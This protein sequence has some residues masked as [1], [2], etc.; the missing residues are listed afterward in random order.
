[1]SADLSQ[2]HMRPSRQ[3]SNTNTPSTDPTKPPLRVLVADDDPIN[4]QLMHMMIDRVGHYNEV[5]EDGRRV[6]EKLQEQS[7]DALLLDMHMPVMNGYEVLKEIRNDL[8]LSSILV[9]AYSARTVEGEEEDFLRAGCDDYLPK[10][11]D[12][13]LLAEKLENARQDS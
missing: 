11:V 13:R 9:I 2:N 3:G 6:L 7:F 12:Q 8:G 4:Q 5:A 1:M 10:P